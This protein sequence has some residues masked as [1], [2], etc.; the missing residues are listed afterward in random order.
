MGLNVCDIRWRRVIFFSLSCYFMTVIA[1]KKYSEIHV[2]PEMESTHDDAWIIWTKNQYFI[3]YVLGISVVILEFFHMID[4]KFDGYHIKTYSPKFYPLETHAAWFWFYAPT[5]VTCVCLMIYFY[6]CGASDA[7][8]DSIVCGAFAFH[9]T[10]RL[11]EEHFGRHRTKIIGFES[12]GLIGSLYVQN[13]FIMC[14]HLFAFNRVHTSHRFIVGL[15]LFVIGSLLNG[16]IHC[17]LCTI[18]RPFVNGRYQHVDLTK[19]SV[20]FTIL[21]KPHYAFE[22]LLWVGLAI[23]TAC[24]AAYLNILWE[25][26]YF[27]YVDPSTKKSRNK[28]VIKS[29]KKDWSFKLS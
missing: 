18:E 12:Y 23:L 2:A 4:I 13:A 8:S 7:L 25:I 16:Y 10:R 5:S 21:K 6:L 24:P 9:F 17:L 28:T 3:I 26:Q 19:H 29:A 20:W 22:I 27:G 1:P 11:V 15:T 14:S